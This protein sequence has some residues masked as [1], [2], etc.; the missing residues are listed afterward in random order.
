M[1][2]FGHDFAAKHTR[3]SLDQ[4]RV[5][6]K[7]E[8]VRIYGFVLSNCS[9]APAT[10]DITD[11]TRKFGQEHFYIFELCILDNTTFE[12]DSRW[13]AD[14]GIRVK[15]ASAGVSITFLHSHGGA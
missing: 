15:Q 12:S 14:H 11:A 7:G 10:V 5:L 3:L 4:D 6:E 2:V 1:P 9:G 13:L 8:S